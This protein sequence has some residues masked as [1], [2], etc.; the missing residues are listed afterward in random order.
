[1]SRC[2][3]R[4]QNQSKLVRAG[5]LEPPQA[6]RP[7]GFSDHLRLSPRRAGARKA[8]RSVCG[9]DYPF[10]L[11]RMA[12]GLRCCP[13]SLYTFPNGRVR[14]GLARDCHFTG[15]PEFEQF[16]IAGFPASTQVYGQVRCVCRFRHA[17]VAVSFQ[18]GWRCA[19]PG[20]I[21]P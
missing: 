9:L 13:S 14:P 11:P 3:R 10:T 7:N 1:M 2:S 5:G 15:S 21:V 18:C 20:W 17:R 6:L 8:P 4:N 16:C 12:P 19:S